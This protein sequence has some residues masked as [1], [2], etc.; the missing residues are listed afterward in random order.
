MDFYSEMIKNVIKENNSE[1]YFQL[2]GFLRASQNLL[3]Y[4]N[5]LSRSNVEDKSG[6]GNLGQD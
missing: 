1:I 4:S 5:S 2:K 6:F 3:T